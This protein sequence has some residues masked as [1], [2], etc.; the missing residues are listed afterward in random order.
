MSETPSPRARYEAAVLA[1]V[2]FLGAVRDRMAADPR[3]DFGRACQ[4][5]AIERRD[6]W[7]ALL[8]GILEEKRARRRRLIR[9]VD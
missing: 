7:H 2:A 3:L 1:Q 6:L 8:D 4:G 5:V 9:D